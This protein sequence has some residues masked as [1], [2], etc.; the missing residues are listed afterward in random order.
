MEMDRPLGHRNHNLCE[1]VASG[2][3][4]FVPEC[5]RLFQAQRQ[6]GQKAVPP[7]ETRAPEDGFTTF[8][9]L[10]HKTLKGHSRIACYSGRA[11]LLLS[12]EALWRKSLSSTGCGSTT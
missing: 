2:R 11:S 9:T 3:R 7:R 5:R 12:D 6:H 4:R 10:F 1:G 8:A